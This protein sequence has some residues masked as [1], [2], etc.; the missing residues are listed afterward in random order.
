MNGKFTKEDLRTGDVILRKDGGVEIVNCELGMLICSNG[1]WNDL[2]D[3]KDD[4]TSVY[5]NKN[6]DVVEV[7]RPKEKCDCCFDA[8][9]I[10]RR[11]TLVYERKE[12]EE[13]TLAEVCR[14]LGKEI[15]II[16]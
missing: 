11:G 16:K 10:D 8:M 7:R 9:K 6:W 13:M 1:G 4:L 5:R 14:L 3:I 12:V 2:K 15:K